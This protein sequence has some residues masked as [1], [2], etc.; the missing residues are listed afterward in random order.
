MH[1][2]IRRYQPYPKGHKGGGKFI[3]HAIAKNRT[4]RDSYLSSFLASDYRKR[5]DKL[6]EEKDRRA[7]KLASA[8]QRYRTTGK[9]LGKVE[10]RTRSLNKAIARYKDNDA[11][12][13]FWNNQAKKDIATANRVN[14]QFAKDHP[15]AIRKAPAK[16]I[17]SGANRWMRDHTYATYN[18]QTGTTTVHTPDAPLWNWDR[19]WGHQWAVEKTKGFK[20]NNYRKQL[21]KLSKEE[22]S[23]KIFK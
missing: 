2:G 13:N 10:R 12:A 1:W 9:G 14:K 5:A 21:S 18:S 11:R 6:E 3:G 7:Y 20:Y 16:T 8:K 17:E 19:G 23:R 4:T 15:N 22:R